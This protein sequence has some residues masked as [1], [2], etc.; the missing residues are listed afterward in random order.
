MCRHRTVIYLFAE[1]Q[2]NTLTEILSPCSPSMFHGVS[3]SGQRPKLRRGPVNVE[4]N[5]VASLS[6]KTLLELLPGA[7]RAAFFAPRKSQALLPSFMTTVPAREACYLSGTPSTR[8]LS[9]QAH[10]TPLSALTLSCFMVASCPS[11][12]ICLTHLKSSWMGGEV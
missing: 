11:C 2:T 8:V 12:H 3:V 4:S 10:Q 5:T 6:P 1:H 9:G 7:P